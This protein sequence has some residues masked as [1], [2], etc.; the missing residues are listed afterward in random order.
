MFDEFKFSSSQMLIVEF[1]CLRIHIVHLHRSYSSNPH[2]ECVRVCDIP[3][4]ANK[5]VY[6]FALAAQI[7]AH[8]CKARNAMASSSESLWDFD[9]DAVVQEESTIM[10]E[11][12]TQQ[13]Q[14]PGCR[15]ERF[16]TSSCCFRCKPD[17]WSAGVASDVAAVIA[18]FQL[19]F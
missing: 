11:L 4:S 2:A 15:S 1:A 5:F 19:D 6:V 8:D 14:S 9:F 7:F 17:H 10:L 16:T 18:I 13:S 3:G 12:D